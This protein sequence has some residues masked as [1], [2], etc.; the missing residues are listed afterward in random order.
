MYIAFFCYGLIEL[1]H[2]Q[3]GLWTGSEVYQVY[4]V[5]CGSGVSFVKFT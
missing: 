3:F 1:L 5:T 4:L 2:Q